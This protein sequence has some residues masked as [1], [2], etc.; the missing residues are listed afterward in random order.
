MKLSRKK[1]IKEGT[2]WFLDLS[3][4]RRLRRI[5]RAKK[6]KDLVFFLKR[7]PLT[8]TY[9]SLACGLCLGLLAVESV[10]EA[11]WLGVITTI[12]SFLLEYFISKEKRLL[13][14]AVLFFSYAVFE[15]L[16]TSQTYCFTWQ[17]NILAVEALILL[18]F[19]RGRS[20]YDPYAALFAEGFVFT[21]GLICFTWVRKAAVLNRMAMAFVIPALLLSW[22]YLVR[23]R[24]MKKGGSL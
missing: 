13:Y 1:I 16:R 8:Q 14:P 7:M 6:K 9:L 5:D 19:K 10:W 12:L 18:L 2:E 15:F 21:A 22:R 4:V 17:K 11:L 23:R 3:W 20:P 24:K